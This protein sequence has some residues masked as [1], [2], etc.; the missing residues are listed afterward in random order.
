MVTH[1]PSVAI[2]CTEVAPYSA[3]VSQVTVSD[4][5]YAYSESAILGLKNLHISAQLMEDFLEIARNNT[6][7][8]L[9]TCG[10]LGAS[11]TE[12]TFYAT[13]LIIP[14][15]EST[16]SSCQALHEEDI[17]NIQNDRSLLPVGWI[18]THP[19]QSCFMSSI[20]L[21]T[22]YPYQVMVPEAIAIVVAPT[23]KTRNYG[24]F[25]LTDPSG[26]NVLKECEEKGFHPHR[27][28]S[29]GRPLYE[30]CS[31]VYINPNLRFEI[32]DLR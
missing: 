13:T 16:S 28:S 23:D 7:K 12:E 9:E 20:D 14:K 3:Q 22:Q 10:V 5:R 31:H 32:F 8:D 19:S 15:Q 25:R 11:L 1:Y 24:I 18:H 21:H 26:M 30:Q 6:D 17:F 4:S 2:S 29:D 27:D